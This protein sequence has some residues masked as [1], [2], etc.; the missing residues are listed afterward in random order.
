MLDVETVLDF[1]TI[2][3]IFRSGYSRVP[4]YKGTKNDIVG[5]LLT[6]DLIM[7]DPEEGTTVRAMIQFFG[8]KVEWLWPDNKLKQVLAMFKSGR[9]HLAM[10]HDVNSESEDKDPF[11]EVKGLV[12]LEDIIEEI[13]QD[14]IVDET[15]LF[16]EVEKETRVDR[17]SFDY[18]RCG[19]CSR[20]RCKRAGEQR[21]NEI[22]ERLAEKLPVVGKDVWAQ[23][24][25]STP[26][27]ALGAGKVLHR[28]GKP[29]T[30]CTLIVTARWTWRA[31]EGW[32]QARSSPRRR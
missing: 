25:R 20:R 23:I 24:V 8:R 30:H 28:K 31:R 27:M 3:M 29:E 9:T 6:K 13:L 21:A 19:C 12:T 18:A 17:E 26:M 11:Y 22:V 7:I 15:D 4:V 14:E 10:V 1:K 32:G 16:V 5:L 2:S